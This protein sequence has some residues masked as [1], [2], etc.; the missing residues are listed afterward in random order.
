LFRMV[1]EA[2][3]AI[4]VVTFSGK[5]A[6][7]VSWEE[8]FLAKA[9]RLGYHKILLGEFEKGLE[10]PKT[11]ETIKDDDPDKTAKY[12]LVD[13]NVKAYSELILSMDTSTSYGKVA[14]NIVRSSKTT[15]YK[16]GNA[17]DAWKKLKRK[18]A[19]ETAPMLQKLHHMF[20]TARLKK[21]S[22][23]DVYMTYLEDLRIKLE[24]MESMMTD[25]Q[26]IVHI[27]NTLPKEYDVTVDM[28]SRR[29]KANIDPLTIEDLR[30]E[31]NQKYE[32]GNKDKYGNQKLSEESSY[33]E[34]D[35]HALYM[36]AKFKGKCNHCGVRGHKKSECWDLHPDKKKKQQGH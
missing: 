18:Y 15:E 7:W 16:W 21:G 26:F 32:R 12:K 5:K 29:V 4:R 1:K 9:C 30:E 20:Y 2:D 14:F 8:K 3:T 34:D 24:S 13:L 28:L 17:Y 31:L 6:D 25:D 33:D 11:S 35:E 23:P 27:L 36:G 22:D 10:I 19:P